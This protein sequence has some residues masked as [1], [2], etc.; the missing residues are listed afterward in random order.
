MNCESVSKHSPLSGEKKKAL[1]S[2][3]MFLTFGPGYTFSGKR[4]HLYAL[5]DLYLLSFYMSTC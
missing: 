2:C 5:E 1:P 4:V 3:I